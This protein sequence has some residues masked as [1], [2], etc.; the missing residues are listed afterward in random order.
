MC[1]IMFMYS[2]AW[3]CD[4]SAVSLEYCYVM[5]KR[6]EKEMKSVLTAA[7]APAAMRLLIHD[8][9]TF[10]AKT[11]TGGMNGS[12]VMSEELK[13]PVNRDLNAL[14]DKLRKVR[15]AVKANGPPAQAMVS[16]ADTIVLAAKVTTE[17]S[18]NKEKAARS[19][20][21][22]TLAQQFGNPFEVKLGRVDSTGPDPDVNIP[23]PGSSSTEVQAFMNA[24]NVKDPSQLGGPLGKKAP[25]WERPT[26]LLWTASE[27]DP[28]AAEAAFAKDPTFDAWKQ[29][30]DKSRATT[31]RQDY[32]IDFITFFNK[33][34][35]LGAVFDKSVYLYD[36]T[37]QVPDRL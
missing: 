27:D 14:V 30:Y 3:L 34:A 26:F 11:K 16:W 12:I 20:K 2:S 13:R 1:L 4:P 21:S 33:L 24:L 9:A 15:E 5:Q 19:E 18:W 7:D 36:L 6:I 8:A 25:F 17:L 22:Q 10:D 35:D 23:A 31:F 32:E 37:I 29:K 28:A